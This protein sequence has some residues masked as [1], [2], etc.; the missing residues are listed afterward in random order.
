MPFTKGNS[1]NR[2]GRPKG[3]AGVAK[4]IATETRDGAEL[5]EFALQVFR[6]ED[7][8]M[9]D[10]QAAHAWLSD[11]GLGKPV[12]TI[13]LH[14]AVTP[15]GASDDDDRAL[16]ALTP[17]QL[18]A[19]LEAERAFEASRARIF[20]AEIVADPLALTDGKRPIDVA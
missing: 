18:R 9:R 10:R 20:D 12:A 8:D 7:A 6:D 11:R 13:D 4:L 5:V 16:E 2:A 19:L 14:A 1:G 15:V 17:Y 3:F